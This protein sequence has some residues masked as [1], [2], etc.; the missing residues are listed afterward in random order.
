MGWGK[1]GWL[2]D[3]KLFIIASVGSIYMGYQRKIYSPAALD[4]RSR[5]GER[6]LTDEDVCENIP[7]CP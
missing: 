2:E 7:E 4:E 3:I 1:W 5:G 6:K